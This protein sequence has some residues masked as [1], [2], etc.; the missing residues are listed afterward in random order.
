MTTTINLAILAAEQVDAA[1]AAPVDVPDAVKEASRNEAISA[2]QA[3]YS[4]GMNNKKRRTLLAMSDH[5]FMAYE[6][7]LVVSR[8]CRVSVLHQAHVCCLQLYGVW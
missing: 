4:M 7:G 6:L 5:A 3:K 8:C 2:M 1:V